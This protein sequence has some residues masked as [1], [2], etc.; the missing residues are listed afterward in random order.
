MHMQSRDIGSSGLFRRASRRDETLDV[1]SAAIPRDAVARNV[2][3]T[4]G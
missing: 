2:Q 1:V 3:I 4:G